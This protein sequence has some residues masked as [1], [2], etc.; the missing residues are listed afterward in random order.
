MYSYNPTRNVQVSY[1]K[2]IHL[3]I[4]ECSQDKECVEVDKCPHTRKLREEADAATGE[5]DKKFLLSS[6]ESLLCGDLLNKTV[7]CDKELEI[8]A[9]ATE[10]QFVKTLT[11]DEMLKCKSD[12]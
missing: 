2:W 11:A 1:I 12:Q 8:V 10:K 7:C 9:P 5:S 6:I 4:P 3:Y